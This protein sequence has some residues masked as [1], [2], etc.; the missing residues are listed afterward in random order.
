MYSSKL[1]VVSFVFACIT[2]LSPT[3]TFA[4]SNGSQSG[5]VFT[6]LEKADDQFLVSFG[7]FVVNLL[8]SIHIRGFNAIGN[9]VSGSTQCPFS[10]LAGMDGCATAPA[11]FNS[12]LSYYDPTGFSDGS[13]FQYGQ[14][15]ARPSQVNWNVAG[16]NYPV[17]VKPAKYCNGTYVSPGVPTAPCSTTPGA[18]NLIDAYLYNWATDPMGFG[19]STSAGG[20][21]DSVFRNA[22]DCRVSGPID[23]KGVDFDPQET[24]TASVTSGVNAM[25]NTGAI[26]II[27]NT[28][29]QFSGSAPTPFSTSQKYY[30][31]GVSG[32]TFQLSASAGGTAI[33]PTSSGNFTF[34]QDVCV[35]FAVE[36]VTTDNGG[37]LV[38]E[39]NRVQN[40][41][42]VGCAPTAP[43]P[44]SAITN[45]LLGPVTFGNQLAAATTNP[46]NVILKNDWFDGG[47]Q[48]PSLSYGNVGQ[49]IWATTY[50]TVSLKDSYLA[51]SVGK[52][53]SITNCQGVDLEDNV[54]KNDGYDAGNYEGGNGANIIHTEFDILFPTNTSCGASQTIINNTLWED[55]TVPDPPLVDFFDGTYNNTIGAA[56]ITS[57]NY[58]LN[59]IVANRLIVPIGTAT[60]TA[61][62]PTISV[63]G[64]SSLWNNIIVTLTGSLPAGFSAAQQY[65]VVSAGTNTIQLSLTSGG[66][67][68]SPT[69]SGN[70]TVMGGNWATENAVTAAVMYHPSETASITNGSPTIPWPSNTLQNGQIVVMSGATVTFT[71]N[72]ATITWSGAAN[73]QNGDQL[74]L[75]G[76]SLPSGFTAGTYYVVNQAS[77]S[78]G[79]SSTLNG[80]AINAGTFTGSK[81]G[82]VIPAG[83]TAG[84]NEFVI[85][86]NSSS[87][88]LTS[89]YGSSANIITPLGN[90][91]FTVTQEA[92][93]SGYYVDDI[94]SMNASSAPSFCDISYTAPQIM[95]AGVVLSATGSVSGNPAGTIST[96]DGDGPGFPYYVWGLKGGTCVN[97]ADTAPAAVVAATTTCLRNDD[98]GNSSC[99]GTGVLYNMGY[100]HKSLANDGFGWG[101]TSSTA[102]PT[103]TVSFNINNN[104]FATDGMVGNPISATGVLQCTASGYTPVVYANANSW[105]VS[106]GSAVAP[107]VLNST[108]FP[109]GTTNPYCIHS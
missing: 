20:F 67:A 87:F 26:P 2:I 86:S 78:F 53:I 17:G 46:F 94:L 103:F 38:F 39:D 7:S 104:F 59:T 51:N 91:N 40:R 74:T 27:N 24:M 90:G 80:T 41:N 56:G 34:S 105:T 70:A 13:I 102:Q 18:T 98:L 109:A 72:S 79:L 29:L 106:A 92:Q 101:Q 35:G 33:T 10:A 14:L 43:L 9:L 50:G 21:N 69:T 82:T 32:S 95:V 71:S 108:Y 28:L 100:Y 60:F 22:E 3:L 45:N 57:A 83:F 58:Q 88:Q 96:K 36:Y 48:L 31:V 65:Y 64:A 93:G 4:Q 55:G 76:S 73:L 97:H 16:I 54:W 81:S 85:N 19:C 44:V 42:E 30:V 77:G 1:L 11:Y 61:N 66:S 5:S 25:T 89:V 8:G 37:N 49:V 12:T 52:I 84:A 23:V 107:V 15:Q 99:S 47:A 6:T 68:I 75:S 62:S 63:P